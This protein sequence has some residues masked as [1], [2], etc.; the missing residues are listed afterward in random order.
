[1]NSIALVDDHILLRNGLAALI[2]SIGFDVLFE[3]N[4][5]EDCISRIKK[6]GKPDIVLMDINMPVKDGFETTLWLKKNHPEIKVLAL[7]MIDDENAVIRMLKNGARGY[8]LKE[9]SP[10]ELKAAINAVMEKGFYYSEMV[11]GSLV[12]S[13]AGDDDESK[14]IKQISQLSEKETE[15]LKWVCTELTYKE[16]AD[17]MKLSPRTVDSYRDHLFYK[18]DMKSRTGLAI[19]AIKNGLVKL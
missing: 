19:Y 4:N 15:F 17:K 13:I 1:M 9:S 2:K 11:T 12:H 14:A 3:A 16:I 6:M 8:L 5:G 18:L 7:T 10:A